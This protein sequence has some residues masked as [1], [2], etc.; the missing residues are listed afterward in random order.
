MFNKSLLVYEKLDSN[1]EQR[2]T[3]SSGNFNE[4]VWSYN[5]L[6]YKLQIK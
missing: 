1:Y 5:K 4:Q 6:H 2:A 3:T